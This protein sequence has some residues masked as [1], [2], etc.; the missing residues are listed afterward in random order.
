MHK[1]GVPCLKRKARLGAYAFVKVT[2][3]KKGSSASGLRQKP[4]KPGRQWFGEGAAVTKKKTK[5][6]RIQAPCYSG[7]KRKKSAASL[8]KRREG[9]PAEAC[10][11]T[12]YSCAWLAVEMSANLRRIEEKGSSCEEG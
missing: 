9:S 5:K 2:G 11:E 8:T 6:G 4:G 10:G 12:R 3:K 7:R 1:G